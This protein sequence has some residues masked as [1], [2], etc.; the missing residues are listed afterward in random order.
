[1][2]P[3]TI[4]KLHHINQEFYQTFAHSLHPRAGAFNPGSKI[5]QEIPTQGSWLMLAAQRAGG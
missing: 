4:A 5:L 3:E 1:M 2:Q